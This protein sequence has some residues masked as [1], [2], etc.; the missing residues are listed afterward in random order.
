MLPRK[1]HISKK[2]ERKKKHV[3]LACNKKCCCS[4]CMHCQSERDFYRMH[5]H[6]GGWGLKG[7]AHK[8]AVETCNAVYSGCESKRECEE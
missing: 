4:H 5:I 8:E 3:R 6:K 1:M 7:D 2:K